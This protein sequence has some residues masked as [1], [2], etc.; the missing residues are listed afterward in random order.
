MRWRRPDRADRR[1]PA[2]LCALGLQAPAHRAARARAAAP[3]RLS[4]AGRAAAGRPRA[5][6]LL[7]AA[8]ARRLP[9]RA[10][11][12]AGGRRAHRQGGVVPPPGR[13]GAR[14]HHRAARWRGWT[15]RW[16]PPAPRVV[17]LG[18][19]LHSARAHAPATWR[20]WS[21]GGR[22]MPAAGAVLVRGNHDRHAG[23]P[24]AALGRAGGRRP[25]APRPA[26]AGCTTPSRARRLRAGRPRAPGVVLG[27]RAHDRLRL[28]CFHFGAAV[29][30][31]PAFG[32]FTGCTSCG[33]G[34][35][36]RVFRRC[37]HPGA[38]VALP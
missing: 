22:A 24:P 10:A 4:C 16:P 23:D 26:G 9:A 36:D 7:P 2:A 21:P 33:R 15:R 6:P 14:G 29:G 20:R 3:D 17:F 8:A 12:A 31:L 34:P 32:A 27:G 38:T 35:G 18:D 30:V 13:A 11:H 1:P 5:Q 28:P 25:A 37:R 19:L